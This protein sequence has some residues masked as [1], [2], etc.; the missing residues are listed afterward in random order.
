M[1]H[2][3]LLFFMLLLTNLVTVAQSREV[4][5]ALYQENKFDEAAQV[6]TQTYRTQ[7]NDENFTLLLNC[8]K[9]LRRFEEAED[10]IKK[11]LK[12][13]K[14]PQLW[15]DLGFFQKAQKKAEK[16]EESFSTALDAVQRNAGLAYPISEQFSKYGLYEYALQVYIRA[17]KVNPNVNF[18]YQKGLVYAE[19][20]DMENM[21]NEYLQLIDQSPNYY[22]NVRDRMARN[23]TDNP[24]S[25]VNTLFRKALIK[26]IQVSQNPLYTQ[27]LIWLFIEEEEYLKA[28]KQQQ[29]LDRRGEPVEAEIF[30]LG[31]KALSK[32]AFSVA[33]EAFTYLLKKGENGAFYEDATYSLLRTKRQSL[34]QDAS[35]SRTT[36]IDLIKEHYAALP[37]LAGD[38]RYAYTLRDIAEMLYF[39]VNQK[40]SGIAV[41]QG[42][43]ETFGSTFEQP[44]GESKMLLGDFYLAQNQPIDAIFK[45]MEVENAFREYTLGDEAKFK[46]G[47][48]AYYTFD[49]TWALTQ[50]EALKASTTKLLSNDALQMALLINDN[51]QEDTLFQGLTY[52]ARA[53][54]YL[55]RNQPDS[56]LMTLDLLLDVFPDHAIRDEALLLKGKTLMA[57]ARYTD[58][59]QTLETMIAA[60]RTIWADDALM[61]LGEIYAEHL[62]NTEKAMQ[63][64]E[65]ILFE[66]SG[67]TRLIEARKRYRALR[68]DGALN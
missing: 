65:K 32:Q 8:Y 48:V 34:Q 20:G 12:R 42:I 40:D 26:R 45:Y 36:Y 59:A 68:G 18:H 67:S 25:E 46:K 55:F 44:V 37:N 2:R 31:N 38:E 27:L 23:I 6:F 3:V 56:A 62:N 13:T 50:F 24:E 57:Q 53:D 10:L 51:S 49:F 5:L 58:A 22:A 19:L 15:V 63:A 52:Y 4:G 61:L 17:E 11:H 16:A 29:A 1:K 39:K 9:E 43:I 60:G 14:N 30:A 64:Y 28:L 66:F 47:M 54:F 21:I 41:L 33:A 35:A 7:P